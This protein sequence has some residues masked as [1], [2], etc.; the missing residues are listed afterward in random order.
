MIEYCCFLFSAPLCSA[1][2]HSSEFARIG[3]LNKASNTIQATKGNNNTTKQEVNMD[4]NNQAPAAEAEGDALN[5]D[6]ADAVG[7]EAKATPTRVYKIKNNSGFAEIATIIVGPDN[8]R[9][10]YEVYLVDLIRASAIFNDMATAKESEK[11]VYRLPP[12]KFTEAQWI[13]FQKFLAPS[14]GGDDI[15]V[16]THDNIQLVVPLFH[17]LGMEWR[18]KECFKLIL[19]S[20]TTN[21]TGERE[22]NVDNINSDFWKLRGGHTD[23]FMAFQLLAKYHLIAM[24]YVEEG[25]ETL[26]QALSSTTSAMIGFLNRIDD[27]LHLFDHKSLVMLLEHV[28][29]RNKNNNNDNATLERKFIEL[30]NPHLNEITSEEDKDIRAKLVKAYLNNKSTEMQLQK[31]RN[32]L[33]GAKRVLSTLIHLTPDNLFDEMPHQIVDRQSVESTARLTLQKVLYDM[34]VNFDDEM[35]SIGLT[36]PPDYY[37][38]QLSD[39]EMAQQQI[40][41]YLKSRQQHHAVHVNDICKEVKTSFPNISSQREVALLLVDALNALVHEN[42]VRRDNRNQYRYN[43]QP[44]N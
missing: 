7:A 41:H 43:S 1:S 38:P 13:A 28:N 39:E 29:L 26:R 21:T 22:I 8:D 40:Y 23:M 3:T 35:N 11:H 33:D 34:L 36:A 12:D 18:L 24:T 4:D 42:K 37:R 32:K 19:D 10:H 16:V 9:A 27:A 31:M 6:A 14:Q 44:D 20:V 2:L 25:H 30:L 17:Y 15:A 5:G